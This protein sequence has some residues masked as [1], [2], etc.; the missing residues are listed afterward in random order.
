MAE[1]VLCLA[2]ARLGTIVFPFRWV[3]AFSSATG[4]QPLLPPERR[5]R[6]IGG[7][8]GA[9]TA[10]SRHTWFRAA[11]LQQALAVQYMLRRRGVE[12]V[13]NFGAAHDADGELAAHA[14]V[15]DGDAV[16]IGGSAGRFAT[17]ARFP[18]ADPRI[19]TP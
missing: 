14:W 10:A 7:V 1:A 18:P 4:R 9:V 15:S 3:A 8:A 5:A 12:T 19:K 13:L 11:C 16:V 17:L 2:C 6:L